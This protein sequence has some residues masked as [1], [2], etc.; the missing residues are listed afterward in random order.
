MKSVLHTTFH[1]ILTQEI[2][3]DHYYSRNFKEISRNRDQRRKAHCS[4]EVA[5]LQHTIADYETPAGGV[6]SDLAGVKHSSLQR[7]GFEHRH[8]L[9]DT[10]WFQLLAL[11]RLSLLI[12]SV[13]RP[14]IPSTYTPSW[15]QSGVDRVWFSLIIPLF[16]PMFLFVFEFGLCFLVSLL[17]PLFIRAK[18]RLY[19]LTVLFST[20]GIQGMVKETEINRIW[21][22]IDRKF[23][24]WI[25]SLPWWVACIEQ[26]C[27]IAGLSPWNDIYTS[28]NTIY[29][30]NY[31]DGKT[32]VK[33]VIALKWSFAK[34]QVLP[35]TQK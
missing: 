34:R 27:F 14:D 29:Y 25:C 13:Q 8:L 26:S 28:V 18:E 21:S 17:M 32:T 30:S 4:T 23:C 11:W 22:F 9:S 35:P 5:R 1:E 20:D 6:W 31:G 10:C 16:I 7:T 2:S 12:C 3:W 24:V 33:K 19:G 15:A